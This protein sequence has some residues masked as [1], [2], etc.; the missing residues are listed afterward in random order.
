MKSTPLRSEAAAK[1]IVNPLVA[2]YWK[3]VN[4]SR[5]NGLG[6]PVAYRLLPGNNVLPFY[7]PDAHAIRRAEF[8]TRHLWVTPYDPGENFPAGDYPSQ[9][10][11]GDGLPAYAA[12]DRPLE[13]TDV[14]LWYAF[15]AHHEVR[16]EDWPV[17]PTS[18][19]GFHLKPQGFFD[20]N[21]ALDVPEGETCQ[22]DGGVGQPSSD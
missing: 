7:Q 6:E 15:G 1:R 22:H 18:S 2:R 19:I 9:H 17:M 3:V 8:A 13:N 16:P 14:V 4:P 11:G 20:G 5:L 12:Q 10:P 21:P